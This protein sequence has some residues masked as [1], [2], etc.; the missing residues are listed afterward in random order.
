V[1]ISAPNPI[2]LFGSPQYWKSKISSRFQC[3][4]KAG[5][6]KGSEWISNCFF[7]IE[8]AEEGIEIYR[9]FFEGSLPIGPA[10]PIFKDGFV[11]AKEC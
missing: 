10:G 4:L 3:N 7:C 8:T 9:K 1:G 5:T 11:I 2:L 6:I